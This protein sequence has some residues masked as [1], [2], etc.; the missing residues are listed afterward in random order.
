V[1]DAVGR[2]EDDITLML[3]VV[4]LVFVVC[5]TPAL[6]TQLLLVILGD[7]AKS[8]GRPFFYYERI[9]DL[10]VVANYSV[11]FVIY[12]FCSRT[13]RQTVIEVV[14]RKP[15][16]LQGQPLKPQQQQL[17]QQEQQMTVRIAQQPHLADVALSGTLRVS[18]RNSIAADYVTTLEPAVASLRAGVQVAL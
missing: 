8:C 18:L 9:S 6:A 13:F 2:S 11:N 17:I 10:M 15:G 1:S 5:Q 12:C 3:I 4:V 14:C 7:P 16:R